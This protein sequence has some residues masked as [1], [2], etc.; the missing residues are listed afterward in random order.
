MNEAIVV[1]SRDQ[2][3]ICRLTLN[4]P[5]RR[6]ALSIALMRALCEQLDALASDGDAR[7]VILHGAGPVFCA[8]L[9][10]KE[11]QDQS[12]AHESAE[13][14]AR[15]MRTVH[16]WP[17]PTIAAVH[18][19]AVAG[20]A[21]LMTACDFA[22]CAEGTQI[23]YP[24]VRRGLVAV[25]VMMFL[26]RQTNDRFAR[27][28]LVS[29]RIIDAATAQ[30]AGLVNEVVPLDELMNVSHALG[31]ELLKCAPEAVAKTKK[32]ID[33]L[34]PATVEEELAKAVAGHKAMRSGEEAL[35]GIR[36]YNEKRPPS[37][38]VSTRPK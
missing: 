35:E 6:N 25:S 21:G 34:W 22:I 33:A 19:A 37:W 1:C 36:A 12:I 10:L 8:G 14:V 2:L 17:K 3:G 4:R 26:L 15:T 32:A 7:V 9:D 23:G 18:G 13:W 29:G 30:R 16:G 24:E 38:D 31:Q 27:D 20:G 11:A 5:D 28:L